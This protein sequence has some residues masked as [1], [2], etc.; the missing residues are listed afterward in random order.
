[1]ENIS[2]EKTVLTD[3][4]FEEMGWHDSKL[5]A[6]A[7]GMKENEIAFDIDY[8]LKWINPQGLENTFKFVVAPATLVFRNV[9]DLNINTSLTEVIIESIERS[10]PVR[11]KN[12]NYI[13]EQLEY[14][15]RIE[16]TNGEISFKSVGYEQFFRKNPTLIDQQHIGLLKRGGISFDQGLW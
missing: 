3:S 1:M 8:I 6:I 5:Y 15:W 9:Y 10:N 4:D 7:F 14:D 12:A 16:T 13:K 11:P 2:L